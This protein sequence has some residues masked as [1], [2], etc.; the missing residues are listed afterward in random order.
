[1]TIQSQKGSMDMTV[2]KEFPKEV[3]P[4]RGIIKDHIEY[5]EPTTEAPKHFHFIVGA[6]I[7]SAVLGRRIYIPWGTRNLYPNIYATIIGDST[8]TRKTTSLNAGRDIL[9]DL[10]QN[11]TIA[12]LHSNK[13]SPEGWFDEL[14]TQAE[15]I[16]IYSEFKSLLELCDKSY[17]EDLKSAL[18][19]WY[20]C[21]NCDVRKLKGKKITI[22]NICLSILAGTT[23]EWFEKSLKEGD[24]FSGFLSRVI[25]I[26]GY[27][28]SIV[29]PRPPA[30][31]LALYQKTISDLKKL[32]SIN[33]PIEMCLS[34]DAE[35]LYDYWYQGIRLTKEE[36]ER[37]KSFKTRIAD[38]S[39][40]FAML[41][42][43]SEQTQAVI[44][45]KTMESSIQP[46]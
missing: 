1:M 33:P 7:V 15:G 5:V 26:P 44:S 36:D 14:S 17:A 40:K 3:Y 6:S 32:H 35:Q 10:E 16:W 31:D 34:N 41:L 2:F 22:N 46:P 30:G 27:D 19:D 37:I 42:E 29:I 8:V 25:F 20:D 18:T 28:T 9:T 23:M 4:D 39:I 45:C 12:T 43:I 11:H 21:P 13:G 24:L 38:Y